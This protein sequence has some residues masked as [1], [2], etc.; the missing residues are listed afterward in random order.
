MISQRRIYVGHT[1]LTYAKKTK[2]STGRSESGQFLGRIVISELSQ[3]TVELDNMTPDWY[4]LYLQPFIDH[5]KTLP[6][7]FA[8][9]PLT[10]PNEVGYAW[11]MNDPALLNSRSNGMCKTTIEMGGIS[12]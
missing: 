5:A 12:P 7:F 8:W 3:A 2:I 6:F 1:P 11:V 9:R 10:Y 4:R